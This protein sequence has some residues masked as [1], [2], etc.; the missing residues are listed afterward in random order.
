[1]A[2]S[3]IDPIGSRD[4]GV[5]THVS[6]LQRYSNGHTGKAPC[7]WIIAPRRATPP[8]H[9]FSHTKIWRIENRCPT[10]RHFPSARVNFLSQKLVNQTID[11]LIESKSIYKWSGALR[12]IPGAIHKTPGT[13]SQNNALPPS[14]WDASPSLG[15]AHLF[16]EAAE[17]K[18]S[19]KTRRQT[20]AVHTQSSL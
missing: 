15:C 3:R 1:M 13:I 12:T 5:D 14:S 7:V 8:C 9:I 16:T 2:W 10:R 6:P 4:G 19:R 17:S 20:A 18:F 11:I